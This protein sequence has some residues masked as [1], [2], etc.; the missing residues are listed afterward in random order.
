MS[1]F[2]LSESI[3]K[4]EASFK[5]LEEA[6]NSMRRVVSLMKMSR[7]DNPH[8]HLVRVMCKLELIKGWPFST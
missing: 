4:L 1:D 6:R 7:K 2:D 5:K 3:K 8:Y